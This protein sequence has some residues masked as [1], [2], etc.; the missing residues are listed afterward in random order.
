[1]Q[2]D[3]IF[4]IKMKHY[5]ESDLNEVNTFLATHT[6]YEVKSVT[7]ISQYLCKEGYSGE[8]N[9]VIVVGPVVR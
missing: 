2:P 8:Y 9:V 5:M 4:I 7:P 3:K 6:T 1:M